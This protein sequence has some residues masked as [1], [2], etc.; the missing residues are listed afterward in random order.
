[1][2]GLHQFGTL[3]K[4]T[5]IN[6]HKSNELTLRLGLREVADD[7]NFLGERGDTMTVNVVSEQVMFRNV[8]AA[9]VD[10]E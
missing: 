10:I 3:R 4:K 2:Y 8:K 6:I 5:V 7:L 9:F 1:M